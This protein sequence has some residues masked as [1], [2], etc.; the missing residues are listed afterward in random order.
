MTSCDEVSE[1]IHEPP[2]FG[3]AGRVEIDGG[4][5]ILLSQFRNPKSLKRSPANI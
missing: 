3:L 1:G 5:N 4:G 2:I